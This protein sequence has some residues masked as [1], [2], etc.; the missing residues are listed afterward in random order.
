MKKINIL[1]IA[2]IL[3]IGFSSCEEVIDVDLNET[4]SK[5]VIEAS[6]TDRPGPYEVKL[7]RSGDYYEPSEFEKIE[8]ARVIISDN[9][10]TVDTLH[11]IGR[12][13]YHTISIQGI[14]GNTYYLSVQT[15]DVE[16]TATATMPEKIMLEDVR[17]DYTLAP[18]P[19]DEDG[20]RVSCEFEDTEGIENFYRFIVYQNDIMYYENKNDIYLWNDDYFDGNRVDLAVKRRGNF[21]FEPDDTIR[22]EML[23]Y[24]EDTYM[25]YTTLL[26]SITEYTKM[27]LMRSFMMGSFAPANPETNLPMEVMGHFAAYCVSEALVVVEE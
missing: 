1:Y 9:L 5:I 27:E 3:I 15:D 4:S 12:G 18:T 8:D 22:V 7:S 21:P 14:P 19:H 26:S 17:C 6:I 2:V 20:Y 10:G 24:N 23:S 11:E 13:I 25:Y 16:I